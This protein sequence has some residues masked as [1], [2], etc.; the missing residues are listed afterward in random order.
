MKHE[1]IIQGEGFI[2]RP[3]TL[4]DLELLRYW[5]NSNKIQK[6]FLDKRYI[7]SKQ[8][9]EWYKKYL[10]NENDI[11][12]IIEDTILN[13]AVGAISLYNIDKK[14]AEFGRFMIGDPE[15]KGKGIGKKAME[16]I[17]KFGFQQLHLNRIN[18]EVIKSNHRAIRI[19]EDLGFI[20]VEHP[21]IDQNNT[22]KMTKNIT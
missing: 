7:D 5:R 22:I 2:L 9:I 19:Y 3:L 21:L 6:W 20:Q 15:A 4:D 12:F 10:E 14:E 16:A 17:C 11:F 8:Q 1:F 13:R 18:L